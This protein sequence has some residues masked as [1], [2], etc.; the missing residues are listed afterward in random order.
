[1]EFNS[2]L[3]IAGTDLPN[4]STYKPSLATVVDGGRNV[5]G[6]FI[7]SVVRNSIEKI[8]V[9]WNVLTMAEW[10][11]ILELFNEDNVGQFVNEVTYFSEL[12]V[13]KTAD[14]YVTDRS[15][16]A[17][18]IDDDGVAYWSGPSFSLVEK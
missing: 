6:V 14:F 9:G 15:A 4:P 1:M 16:G 18:K 3:S 11:S 5:N 13:R 17:L 8:A 2:L 12:G 10:A 7:G